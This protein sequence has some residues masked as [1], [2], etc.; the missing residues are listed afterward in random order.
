MSHPI[1][2]A[3]ECKKAAFGSH[4]KLVMRAIEECGTDI[5]TDFANWCLEQAEEERVESK[6]RS[7]HW[8]GHMPPGSFTHITNFLKER[9]ERQ[10]QQ[11]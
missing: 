6:G 5:L 2:I 9:A 10:R 8:R 4:D 7:K 11:H 1:R 3:I